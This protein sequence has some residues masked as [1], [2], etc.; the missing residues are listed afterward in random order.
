MNEAK[1]PKTMSLPSP[2]VIVSPPVP[3]I[4]QFVPVPVIVIVSGP[5][6]F[7]L[8][9]LIPVKPPE[10]AVQPIVALSPMTMFEPPATVIVSEPV[11]PTM[12][13]SPPPVEI[14]SLPP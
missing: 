10:L 3:P 2:V 9:A 7:G 14:V 1:S 6:S 11:P 5:P 4:T 13:L 8:I 12:T